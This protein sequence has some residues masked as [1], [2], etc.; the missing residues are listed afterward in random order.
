MRGLLRTLLR[1]RQGNWGPTLLR[2]PLGAIFIAHGAQKL[3][4]WF[5]GRGLKPTVEGFEQNLHI[6]RPLAYL[7]PF[8]EF[9][10]GL[11]VLLGFATRPAALGL[12]TVMGVATAKVHWREGFF[13]NWENQPGKGHGIEAPAAFGLMALS[14]LVTGGGALSVDG[15]LSPAREEELLEEEPAEMLVVEEEIV[16]CPEVSVTT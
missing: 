14:L 15:A 3:F 1:T 8:T 11:A 5:G 13:M 7:N 12:A 16:A 10:G 6:P 4:G 9:F 2:L